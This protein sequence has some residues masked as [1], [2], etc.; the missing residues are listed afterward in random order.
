MERIKSMIHPSFLVW[1]LITLVRL[2]IHW[3]C[4]KSIS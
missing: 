1:V 3:T 2:V 4:L